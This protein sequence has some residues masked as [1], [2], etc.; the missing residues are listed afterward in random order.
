MSARGE[1]NVDLAVTVRRLE[2]LSGELRASAQWR[3]PEI[4]A[5][6]DALA[7]AAVLLS[8]QRDRLDGAG[9]HLDRLREAI[10]LARSVVETS[11]FAAWEKAGSRASPDGERL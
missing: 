6:S 3:V 7:C 2:E 8:T 11:K 4:S 10:G 1:R 5:A 9:S